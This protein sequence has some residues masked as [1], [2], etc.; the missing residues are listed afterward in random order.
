MDSR[1]VDLVCRFLELGKPEFWIVDALVQGQ[2][3]D[4]SDAQELVSRITRE[5]EAKYRRRRRLLPYGV[6]LLVLSLLP[7]FLGLPG[8]T[9]QP[10]IWPGL[11]DEDSKV[12]YVLLITSLVGAFL[13]SYGG[14]GR[15]WRRPPVNPASP[16]RLPPGQIPPGWPKP[17][18]SPP[19][20]RV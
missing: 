3:M 19:I 12:P 17:D 14:A 2:N 6:V 15:G 1:R 9:R 7:L 10:P 11:F 13:F 18:K 4:R 8:R 5:L 20:G 16:Q